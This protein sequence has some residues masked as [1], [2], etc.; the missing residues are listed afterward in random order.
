MIWW[1]L[2]RSGRSAEEWRAGAE[3]PIS[4]SSHTAFIVRLAVR[5]SRVPRAVTTA[6]THHLQRNVAT[7]RS[8][9][10]TASATGP[11]ASPGSFLAVR[12][13]SEKRVGLI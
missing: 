8:T 6:V 2:S 12:C 11:R 1:H 5:V 13:A 3:T 9:H 7:R 10:R 4:R